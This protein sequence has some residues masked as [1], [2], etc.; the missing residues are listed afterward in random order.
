MKSD[1][2]SKLQI[3]ALKEVMSIGMAHSGSALSKLIDEKIDVKLKSLDLV[4]LSE[5]SANMGNRNV[6]STGVYLRIMGDILGT[7]LL[8]LPRENALFIVDVLNKRKQGTTKILDREDRSGLEEVG[9]ILTASFLNA[10]S[11]FLGFKLYPSTPVTVFD[12]A[13]SIVNFVLIGVKKSVEFGLLV[14]VEFSGNQGIISGNFI[15]LMD[16]ESLRNLI[17]VL[18][19]RIIESKS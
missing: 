3:D 12:V 19:K 8:V 4:P 1:K 7:T 18:D 5:I 13:G 15:L 6:L 9:S 11:D 16:S 2:I 10:V 14:H 17:A